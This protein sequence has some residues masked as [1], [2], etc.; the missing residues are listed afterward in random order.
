M[1]IRFEVKTTDFEQVAL[2]VLPWQ[3][4][5]PALAPPG[6]QTCSKLEANKEGGDSR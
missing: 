1:S 2:A 6:Q 5:N 4:R 3:K